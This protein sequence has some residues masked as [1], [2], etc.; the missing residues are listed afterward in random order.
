MWETRLILA[1]VSQIRE[2]FPDGFDNPDA[3]IERH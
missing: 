2:V 1:R 3:R